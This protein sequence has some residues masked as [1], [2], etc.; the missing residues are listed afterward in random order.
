VIII[1]FIEIKS[2]SAG[3]RPVLIYIAAEVQEAL[4]RRNNMF[5]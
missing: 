5:P 4:S 2:S 1:N 3:N